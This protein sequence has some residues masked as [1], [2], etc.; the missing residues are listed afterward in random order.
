MAWIACVYS[1]RKSFR[2][3][4]RSWYFNSCIILWIKFKLLSLLVASIAMLSCMAL[5]YSRKVSKLIL[6]VGAS[7]SLMF[8]EVH[9]STSASIHLEDFLTKWRING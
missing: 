2:L 1:K 7:L 6:M 8:K 5:F 3:E 9:I 4:V